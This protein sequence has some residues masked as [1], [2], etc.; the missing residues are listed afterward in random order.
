MGFLISDNYILQTPAGA[1]Q[2]PSACVDLGE[3]TQ[4]HEVGKNV[5]WSGGTST[6]APTTKK[7]AILD[8]S[9]GCLILHE[10]VQGEQQ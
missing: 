4:Y 3:R 8:R 10:V 6:M 2:S 5:L 7:S 9:D 1:L